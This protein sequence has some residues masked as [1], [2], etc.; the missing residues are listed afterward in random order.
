MNGRPGGIGY[1]MSVAH[2][3][4][5]GSMPHQSLDAVYVFA[6]TSEPARKSVAKDCEIQ[7]VSPCHPV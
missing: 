5:N 2:S 4:C 1:Q 6:I 7:F 3:H